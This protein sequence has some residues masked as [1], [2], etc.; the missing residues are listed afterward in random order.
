MPQQVVAGK[1]DVTYLIMVVVDMASKL[2]VHGAHVEN[3]NLVS[4]IIDRVKHVVSATY[5][6]FHFISARYFLL[7]MKPL[8]NFFDN[9]RQVLVLLLIDKCLY[10]ICKLWNELFVL[11]RYLRVPP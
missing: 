2:V 7:V 3:K 6:Y 10:I 5:F 8:Y 9:G 11:N 1:K 4:V